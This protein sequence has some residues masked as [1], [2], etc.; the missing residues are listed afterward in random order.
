M[1]GSGAYLSSRE[2]GETEHESEA[3]MSNTDIDR[4][5][6]IRNVLDKKL[7]QLAAANILNLGDRQVRR[8]CVQVRSCGN[9]GEPVFFCAA[10]RWVWRTDPL[11]T[12]WPRVA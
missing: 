3:N 8:L 5:R 11:T 6:V 10:S 1:S 9:R 7:T 4:L 12:T 2:G